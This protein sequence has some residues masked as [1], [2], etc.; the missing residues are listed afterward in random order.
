MWFRFPKARV[1]YQGS[2]AVEVILES[3]FSRLILLGFNRKCL[4]CCF[5]L[6]G[7][8]QPAIFPLLGQLRLQQP[9]DRNAEGNAYRDKHDL[10]PLPD[11]FSSEQGALDV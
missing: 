10:D 4:T 11:R 5:R 2:H 1:K 8:C 7:A 6:L 9:N 3:G